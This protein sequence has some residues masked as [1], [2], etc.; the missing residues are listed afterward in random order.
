MK[1]K[2][3]KNNER[4]KKFKEKYYSYHANK[5]ENN[6]SASFQL[7]IIFL[8]LFMLIMAFACKCMGNMVVAA[9]SYVGAIIYIAIPV[10]ISVVKLYILGGKRIQDQN[11]IEALDKTFEDYLGKEC[12]YSK[13]L[14][15]I[16]AL[17]ESYS[18]SSEGILVSITKIVMFI[19]TQIAVL[20]LSLLSSLVEL[21]NAEPNRVY[22]WIA[23]NI[24]IVL[25]DKFEVVDYLLYNDLLL[26]ISR[27]YRKSLSMRIFDTKL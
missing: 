3:T 20:S 10:V 15:L 7:A 25:L 16:D 26:F 18:Q 4:I 6:D 14:Q 27:D 8:A 9:I 12:D 2:I 13:Q 19:L 11:R 1:E 23:I 5:N 21:E 24:F 17:K 22:I